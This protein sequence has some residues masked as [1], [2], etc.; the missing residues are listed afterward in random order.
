MRIVFVVGSA[1]MGGT[2]RNVLRL[3]GAL[4]A[5]GLTV[6]VL[7][8]SDGGPLLEAYQARRI[9]VTT[10]SWSYVCGGSRATWRG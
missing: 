9:P 1:Q 7:L 2:E 8:L 4:L 3:A 6:E 10:V 5:R